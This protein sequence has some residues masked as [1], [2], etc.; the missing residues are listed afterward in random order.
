MHVAMRHCPGLDPATLGGLG[1]TFVVTGL[2]VQKLRRIV[3]KKN[4]MFL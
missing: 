4:S 3:K 2:F 1:V